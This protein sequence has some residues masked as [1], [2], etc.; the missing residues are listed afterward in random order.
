MNRHH[1]DNKRKA[2]S[3]SRDDTNRDPAQVPDAFETFEELAPIIALA[4]ASASAEPPPG[5]T[6]RV[7]SEISPATEEHAQSRR[8]Y[9]RRR[10]TGLLFK[11]LTQAASGTD[12][13]LCF[14]LAG[15]F[16]LILGIVFFV[17]LKSFE[18]RLSAAGWFMLQPR[19]AFVTAGLLGALGLILMIKGLSGVRIAYMGVIGYILFSVFNGIQLHM[20]PTS[21]FNLAGILCFVGGSV[22][23]GLF[24]TATVRKYRQ[25][26][27]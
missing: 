3:Q 9:P 5:F 7:M 2:P 19:I 20:A 1:K 26:T 18:L 27:M 21:P 25:Q 12:I 4:K 16:Y 22:L 14:F 10:A 8:Y 15:F 6:R 11:N 24:L 13:A 23:L 17:G